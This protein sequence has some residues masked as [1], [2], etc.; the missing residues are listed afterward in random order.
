MYEA[1]PAKMH[2]FSTNYIL[3]SSCCYDYMSATSHIS[4]SSLFTVGGLE[5][6]PKVSNQLCFRGQGRYNHF[7]VVLQVS[8]VLNFQ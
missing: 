5:R 4:P 2:F 3:F 6:S 8:V 7:L 1:L